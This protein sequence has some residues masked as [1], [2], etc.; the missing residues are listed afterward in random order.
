VAFS[1]LLTELTVADT[2]ILASIVDPKLSIATLI[3]IVGPS[4]VLASETL[5]F[6]TP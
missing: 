6:A 4:V 1:G 3:A 5:A 2:A